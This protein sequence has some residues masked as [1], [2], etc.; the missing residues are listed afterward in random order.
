MKRLASVLGVLSATL[1]ALVVRPVKTYQ[2]FIGKST[3][4]AQTPG[5]IVL[6]ALA[7][8]FGA[9]RR[10]RFATISGVLGASVGTYY[11]TRVTS[12]H[13]GLERAFG[14]DWKQRIPPDAER[15]MLRHRR[16]MRL[17][18][19]PEPRWTRDVPFSPKRSASTTPPPPLLVREIEQPDIRT[20]PTTAGRHR[21]GRRS[22]CRRA[23]SS[24]V[25][26]SA[27]RPARPPGPR[28]RWRAD[29]DS[30]RPTAPPNRLG[31]AS[32]AHR[33]RTPILPP[34]ASAAQGRGSRRPGRGTSHDRGTRVRR[35]AMLRFRRGST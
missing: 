14:S 16:S 24:P 35:A 5:L 7:A 17:R 27:V 11:I 28:H 23:Q 1:S 8:L 34:T 18:R 12:S 10:A 22:C 20:P 31:R 4:T 29:G 6:G 21:C 32:C 30:R 25:V 3:A 9:R 33:P 19:V 13:D 15:R 2:G 26:R